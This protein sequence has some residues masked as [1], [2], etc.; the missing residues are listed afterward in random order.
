M[1]EWD[2]GEKRWR[3]LMDGGVGR[4]KEEVAGLDVW[5]SG[6]RERGEGEAKLMEEWDEGE[7]RG[8]G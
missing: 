3:G 1:G 7:T 6:M 8:Q 4:G 5:R 2:E